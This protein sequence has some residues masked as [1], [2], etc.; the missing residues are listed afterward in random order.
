MKK[1][2]LI[3]LVALILAG[4][5][6]WPGFEPQDQETQDKIAHAFEC[7]WLGGCQ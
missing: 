6:P 7:M 4:C 3:A 1:L 5:E 2:L